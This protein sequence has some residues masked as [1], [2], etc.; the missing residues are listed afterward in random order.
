MAWEGPEPFDS[1]SVIMTMRTQKTQP[2][3]R[4]KRRLNELRSMLFGRPLNA[5]KSNHLSKLD[6]KL[7]EALVAS[8]ASL[9]HEAGQCA[10]FEQSYVEWMSLVNQPPSF[11][12][13][14][15]KRAA[16]MFAIYNDQA[17]K[18]HFAQTDPELVSD[19]CTRILPLILPAFIAAMASSPCQLVAAV[20]TLAELWPQEPMGMPSLLAKDNPQTQDEGDVSVPEDPV[21]A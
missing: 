21:R 1:S 8:L 3:R 16:L 13:V 5:R 4:R 19:L 9:E 11:V 12:A 18:A 15:S 20:A 7:N 17:V 6:S 2:K 10:S 14:Q